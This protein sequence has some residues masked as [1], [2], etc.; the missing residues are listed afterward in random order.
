[1]DLAAP[2]GPLP[3]SDGGGVPVLASGTSYACAL[4]TAAVAMVVAA[5]PDWS[6]ERVVEALVSGADDTPGLE[7]L[8]RG[9]RLRW[10][11]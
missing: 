5:H 4:A 3:T 1:V 9:G 2:G 7:G 10:P 8:V 11:R 6:P